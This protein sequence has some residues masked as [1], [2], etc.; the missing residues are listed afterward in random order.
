MRRSF[1]RGEGC[2][3]CHDSGC[4]GRIGIYEVLTATAEFREMVIQGASLDQIRQWY[5][6]QGGRSLFEQG[7]RLA[8][9]EVTSLEEVMRAAFVE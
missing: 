1:A 4:Q 3:K 8:E 6:R 7:V 2:P 5:S 9:Q